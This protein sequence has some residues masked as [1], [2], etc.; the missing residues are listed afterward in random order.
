M[1]GTSGAPAGQG[2]TQ[3]LG[4]AMLHERAGGAGALEMLRGHVGSQG[5]QALLPAAGLQAARAFLQPPL[6]GEVVRDRGLAAWGR[7]RNKTRRVI[8][9]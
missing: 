1:A 4:I 7:Y 9:C 8:S 2:L 3:Y 5:M 6:V